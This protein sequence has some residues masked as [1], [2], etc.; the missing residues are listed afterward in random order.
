M[1][2]I[3]PETDFRRP[4]IDR[5]LDPDSAGFEI[6]GLSE[7]AALT[8]QRLVESDPH[9]PELQQLLARAPRIAL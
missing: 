4:R 5:R 1:V 9:P 7:M 2:G 8:H 3:D 6:E